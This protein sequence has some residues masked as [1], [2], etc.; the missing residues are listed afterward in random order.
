[1]LAGGVGAARFLRGL[2][3]LLDP[4]RITIIVNTGD[5]EIFFGLHVSPDL[6]TI[7]YTLGGRVDPRNGWGLAGDSFACLDAMRTFYSET[8]FRIGDRDMATHIFRTDALRQGRSLAHITA[9]IAARFGVRQ[10]I[11]PMTNDRVRTLVE[12][13]G[14]GTIPFQQYLVKGA[15]RGRVRRVRFAGVR[16]ARPA[17]GV[18][19]AIRQAGAVILPPSNPIVS[20]LPILS[21]PGVRT[22]LRRTKAGVAAISPLVRG[23]P[24][25]GPLHRI[26]SGLGH[27]IS[28]AGVARLYRG[29]VDV[30]VL[31]TQDAHLAG[32]VADLGMRPLVADTI[33]RDRAQ[34]RSLAAAV[35]AELGR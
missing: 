33:M 31:D 12:I 24:I 11:L 7:T 10:K 8:W 6:D 21:V 22:A 35:L 15:G 28:A 29:L 34:S 1:M 18:L 23:K 30:F 16:S 2:S 4:G 20:I 27:E 14:R 13:A 5:D 17:R 26:L 32:R 19:R 25:K 3:Q 9:A